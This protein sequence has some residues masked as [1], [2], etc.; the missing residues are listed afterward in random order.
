M[1]RQASREAIKY[2][3]EREGGMRLDV[4][5]DGFGYPTVGVGH[6][7]VDADNLKIGDT[8]TIEQGEAFLQDDLLEA[9]AGVEQN[10]QIEFQH[11]IVTGKQ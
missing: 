4:H 8:I 5:D 11:T 1:T 9:R 10:C 7:V 3:T 6:L 2:L